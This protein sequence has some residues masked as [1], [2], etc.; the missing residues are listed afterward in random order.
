MIPTH[1]WIGIIA[2]GLLAIQGTFTRAIGPVISVLRLVL[3]VTVA[4]GAAG[5][6]SPSF[7]L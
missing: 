3:M 7:V 2:G 6:K 4:A 1:I 5:Q